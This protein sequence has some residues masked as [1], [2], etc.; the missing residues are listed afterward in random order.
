[1]SMKYELP[2]VCFRLNVRELGTE[3]QPANAGSLATDIIKG[4]KLNCPNG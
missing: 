3:W 2:Q 1:M 4:N